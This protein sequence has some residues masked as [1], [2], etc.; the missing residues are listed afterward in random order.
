[1]YNYVVVHS[2]QFRNNLIP[3]SIIE[4]PLRVVK[5]KFPPFLHF[6]LCKLWFPVHMISFP[7]N[8]LLAM[9]FLSIL[10]LC[11]RVVL[12]PFWFLACILFSIHSDSLSRCTSLSTLIPCLHPFHCPVW[13]PSLVHFFFHSDSLPAYSSWSSLNSCLTALLCA[14]WF[15]FRVLISEDLM[16][17]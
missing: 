6:L 11:L 15:P 3:S 4:G 2:I 7:S 17:W 16:M 13:F 10:I 8:S 1:M 12:Y 9:F 5:S 14:F